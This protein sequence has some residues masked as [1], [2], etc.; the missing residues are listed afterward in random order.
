MSDNASILLE[1][2]QRGLAGLRPERLDDQDYRCTDCG[3]L[4]FRGILPKGT[5]IETVCQ[6]RF[7]SGHQARKKVWIRVP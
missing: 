2:A 6:K 7:C 4:L 5:D 1:G 3:H